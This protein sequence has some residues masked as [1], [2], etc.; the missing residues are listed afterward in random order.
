M[1]VRGIYATALASILMENGYVLADLSPILQSRINRPS[2]EAPPHVTVKNTDDRDYL[3]VVGYPWDAGASVSETLVKELALVV[4]YRGR[5]GVNTVA[6]ALSLGDCKVLLPG[7][8]E[9]KMRT[10]AGGCPRKGVR[11]RVT[12]V[13]EA[14][15]P[16][17]TILVEPS[18][19]MIGE[20]VMVSYPGLG[21]SFSEHIRSEERRLE[22][23]TAASDRVDLERFHVRFRSSAKQGDIEEIMREVEKLAD[24]TEVLAGEEP[25]EPRVVRRGEYISL[26]LL[27]LP[28]KEKMDEHRSRLTPTIKFHHTLKAAGQDASLLVD[29]AEYLAVNSDLDPSRLG[30]HTLSFVAEHLNGRFMDILHRKP[31]GT[32]FNL[33]PGKVISVETRA[34]KPPVITMKRI[35]R[36]RGILDGLNVEKQ[37][38]DY[39]ITR[40]DTGSWQIINEYYSRKGHFYGVY[41]NIA[42]P[43]ELAPDKIRYLDLYIDVVQKPGQEP[44]VIDEEELD[45]A[46]AEGVINK[47]LYEKAREVA[48]RAYRRL[49][50]NPY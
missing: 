14:L 7:G 21:F 39:S 22:L 40:F 16:G 8:V 29:Y 27:P 43:P 25:G 12:V 30:M 31:D 32:E 23:S 4:E 50:S 46:Y 37:P 41:V 33:T 24:E 28:A 26:V 18:V 3:L 38:G 6:D 13:K 11:M 17:D 1:R 45:R 2:V 49:R 10:R 5:Y 44:M 36:G 42:T 9:A 15:K 20:Y 34:R 48:E 47:P 19:K 35:F